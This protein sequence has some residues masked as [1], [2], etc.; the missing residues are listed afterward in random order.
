MFVQLM[1]CKTEDSEYAE[2]NQVVVTTLN[3]TSSGKYL[4]TKF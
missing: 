3:Y 4:K 2:Y 1:M